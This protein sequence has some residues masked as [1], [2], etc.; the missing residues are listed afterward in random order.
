MPQ[1]WSRHINK[2]YR[3][4]AAASFHITVLDGTEDPLH[5]HWQAV[6]GA[7]HTASELGRS[8]PSEVFISILTN[9]L[10]LESPAAA[11]PI[12]YKAACLTALH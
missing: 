3:Y 12:S 7:T 6:T 2:V 8:A 1:T 10:T 4:S 9:K 11:S 5:S